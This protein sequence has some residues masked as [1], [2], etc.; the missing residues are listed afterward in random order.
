MWDY[1]RSR[2]PTDPPEDAKTES[3]YDDE[4]PDPERFKTYLMN[5]G[6]DM[7]NDFGA[8]TI[9]KAEEGEVGY[10]GTYMRHMSVIGHFKNVNLV[11][12]IDIAMR[13]YYGD[14]THEEYNGE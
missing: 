1:E 14:V 3:I 4:L 6:I 2:W 7:A 8:W 11:Q 12:A 13:W 5:G 10:S 9:W